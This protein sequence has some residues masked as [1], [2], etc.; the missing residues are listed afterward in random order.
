MTFAR[1]SGSDW[2]P[3]SMP[4]GPI[5]SWHGH[6]P[7]T[8]GHAT[9]QPQ[10]FSAG[11][12]LGQGAT[13][14]QWPT[15]PSRSVLGEF[16]AAAE[17]GIGRLAGMTGLVP[18]PDDFRP[19]PAPEGF[20]VFAALP[21]PAA[22]LARP[23]PL[24]S[25][26]SARQGCRPRPLLGLGAAAPA[27]GMSGTLASQMAGGAAAGLPAGAL[28]AATTYERTWG[29]PLAAAGSG[30]LNTAAG[31]VPVFS[32]TGRLPVNIGADA[33]IRAAPT[34]PRP[35]AMSRSPAA[36]AAPMEVDPLAAFAAGAGMTAGTVDSR[37]STRHRRSPAGS[38]APD[39]HVG[40]CRR[41]C[42]LSG[43]LPQRSDPNAIPVQ[44]L[45]RADLES[46]ATQPWADSG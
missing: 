35:T 41:R 6:P 32:A 17:S 25:R 45:S 3:H 39:G 15:Q 43:C 27:V 30:I 36:G 37:R 9:Q 21:R 11:D 38:R 12:P 40:T 14:T 20:R 28:G 10:P 46:P 5:R 24:L 7:T 13:G 26:A 2:K 4:P 44:A 18:M 23:H 8:G 1:A 34:L 19:S 33:L 42:G 29:S 22:S 31:A 16:T